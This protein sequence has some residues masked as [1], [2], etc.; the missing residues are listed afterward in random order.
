VPPRFAKVS[1]MLVWHK[2]A[3]HSAAREAFFEVMQDA[4]SCRAEVQ[5]RQRH[6][7]AA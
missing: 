6:R 7:A 1:T 2:D 5:G 4:G 3:Q